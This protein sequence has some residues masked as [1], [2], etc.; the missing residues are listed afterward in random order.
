MYAHQPRD[1]DDT[2]GGSTTGYADY[3]HETGYNE[4]PYFQSPPAETIHETCIAEP[5]DCTCAGCRP[6]TCDS[7]PRCGAD[8]DNTPE[9]G[10]VTDPWD[11]PSS[12]YSKGTAA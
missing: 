9:D 7:C 1:N 11:S 8:I 2:Y 3:S 12:Y 6:E 4:F 10:G 5:C